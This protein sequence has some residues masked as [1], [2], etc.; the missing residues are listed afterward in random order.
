M[1]GHP[2]SCRALVR[3][4]TANCVSCDIDLQTDHD[5]V[6]VNQQAKCLSKTTKLTSNPSDT[7][8]HTHIQDRLLYLE[9]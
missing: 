7:H 1:I 5:N 8:R 4:V 2:S 6:K 3:S 9:H